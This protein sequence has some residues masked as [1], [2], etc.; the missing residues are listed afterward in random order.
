MKKIFTPQVL[1]CVAVLVALN[2]ILTKF[3]SITLVYVRISFN[4]LPIAL[5]SI[6]YGPA[7][8]GIAALL[9]DVIGV[10]IVGEPFLWGYSLSAALYGITYGLFLH[11]HEKSYKNISSCVILQTIFIDILLGAFWAHI[12]F[13]KPYIIAVFGRAA[14]AIPMSF[15][16]IYM[17]KYIWKYTGKRLLNIIEG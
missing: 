11:N 6:L 16:K 13:G 1:S 9:A 8:G 5:G 7:V 15:I 12:F 10:I 17:I 2:V 14:D 3:L 4:F